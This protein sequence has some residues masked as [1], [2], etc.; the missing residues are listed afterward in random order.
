MG[1]GLN[2]NQTS[3]VSL[4]SGVYMHRPFR[5]YCSNTAT[6]LKCIKVHIVLGCSATLW[7]TFLSSSLKL[8]VVLLSCLRKVSSIHKPG[9]R[10]SPQQPLQMYILLCSMD[11]NIS[12]VTLLPP[13]SI[14]DSAYINTH[15]LTNP[16]AP[17]IGLQAVLHSHW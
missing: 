8:C 2:N 10:W 13:R 16:H 6:G 7:M 9:L 14:L 4:F 3:F 11:Q 15:C 5:K 17:L 12:P 1:G